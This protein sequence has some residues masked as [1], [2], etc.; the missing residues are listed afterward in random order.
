MTFTA[1]E[2]RFMARAFRLAAKG[3]FTTDPNPRVGCVVVQ[4]GTVVGEG[5][6]V[7]AGEAHAEVLALNQAGDRARN[8][9]MFVTLEPCNHYGRTP[10]CADAVLRSG[11][12]RVI[13]AM[14]DPNPLTDGKGVARL[15]AAGIDVQLGLLEAQAQALNPGFIRRAREGRPYVR[16]KIGASLDG[17]IA[18]ASGESRWISG[19]A[20]R[21]DV[22]RLRARSSAV[23]TGIGTVLADDP[24]LTVRN[25]DIGRQPLRVVLD[26]RLRMSP[27]ARML[28]QPGRTLIATASNDAQRAQV[29][30]A[31]GAEIA[32][33]S[34]VDGR[35]D[36]SGLMQFLAKFDLNEILIEA[37]AQV[38]GAFLDA[39]LVDELVVYLAPT[40]LGDA[41]RGMFHLPALRT[42]AD[43]YELQVTDVRAVGDDWRVTAKVSEK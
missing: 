11:V 1:T 36:L 34:G 5:W 18:M 4:D 23:V 16:V 38:A 2:A 30:A 25:W 24:L 7:R 43:R 28:R 20:A 15:R 19:S 3:L 29:L 32:R 35:T 39:G 12:R 42:L 41:G 9:D 40:L 26:S 37:G 21:A 33:L 10:P 31:A 27:N 22:Q 14:Q 17:R 13:C 8:A 6:H